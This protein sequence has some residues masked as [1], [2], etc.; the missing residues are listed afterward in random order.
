MMS[1]ALFEGE[2]L[3]GLIPQRPPMVMV[4]HLFKATETEAET[5]LQIKP[6]NCFCSDNLFTEPGLIE[7][8]AQSAAAFA[9]YPHYLAGKKA[10]L[11]FI[12][13]IRKFAAYRLPEAGNMIHTHIQVVSEIMGVTLIQAETTLEGK[14][15]ASCQM[16]IFIQND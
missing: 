7:H 16:K 13:E 8:I 9:G 10:P 2:Q 6:D 12:G 3:Y 15:V 4:S 5:A 1:Q 14:P 11:G